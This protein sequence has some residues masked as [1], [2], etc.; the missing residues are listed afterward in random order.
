MSQ[1]AAQTCTISVTTYDTGSGGAVIQA[2]STGGVFNKTYR[3]YI[4][5]SQPYTDFSQTTLVA[6]ISNVT[7]GSPTVSFT[8]LSDQPGLYWV[9]VTDANGCVVNSS[10]SISVGGYIQTGD[11]TFS[12]SGRPG[13]FNTVYNP[14]YLQL[15]DYNNYVAN[16]NAYSSTMTLYRSYYGLAW[17]LGSGYIYDINGYC[18]FEISNSG[19]LS[20]PQCT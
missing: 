7:S 15:H 12:S 13:Q 16:G 18:S 8:G 2:T 4:D 14:I 3:L 5:D 6:T 9:Q 10:T 19:V 20:S 17:D 11:V 1:P